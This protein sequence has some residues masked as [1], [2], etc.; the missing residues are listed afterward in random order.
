LIGATGWK[1]EGGNWVR[2]THP[3][4]SANGND[5]YLFG[6]G[7][8]QDTAIDGDTTVGNTDTLRFKEGVAREEADENWRWQDSVG[9]ANGAMWREAA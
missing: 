3:I 7:D 6:R 2:D 1:W 8:G 5:T 9:S 4:V